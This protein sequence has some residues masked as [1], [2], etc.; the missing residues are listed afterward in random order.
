[1]KVGKYNVDFAGVKY[2]GT[3]PYSK[4]VIEEFDGDCPIAM[5][6]KTLYFNIG[7]NFMVSPFS[8]EKEI[9]DYLGYPDNTKLQ[10]ST[11]LTVREVGGPACLQNETVDFMEMPI[12]LLR[13]E[14]LQGGDLYNGFLTS[15]ESSLREQLPT[16]QINI[17]TV[18]EEALR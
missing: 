10:L 4:V 1:M 7:T 17:H 8:T 2:D 15:I 9:E 6:T 3:I 18:A 14:L 13:A 5:Y 11:K 12:A 16:L